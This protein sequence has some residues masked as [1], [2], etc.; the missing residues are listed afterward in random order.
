MDKAVEN[1]AYKLEKSRITRSEGGKRSTS[2][3]KNF[4][5]GGFGGIC[6]IAA[7]HPFD[8]IKV[9]SLN[10]LPFFNSTPRSIICHKYIQ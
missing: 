6:G 3:L 1:K 8:T 9:G 10:V 7:G 4:L 5:A 2:G